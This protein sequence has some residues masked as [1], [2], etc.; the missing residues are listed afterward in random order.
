M[1]AS[2]F[3]YVRMCVCIL[4]TGRE[5]TEGDVRLAEG[6]RSAYDGSVEVCLDGMWITVCNAAW[7]INDATVVCRQLGYDGGQCLLGNIPALCLFLP[8][9]LYSSFIRIICNS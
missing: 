4:C 6:H 5:C 7:D 3:M 9:S 2:V 8:L 1:C